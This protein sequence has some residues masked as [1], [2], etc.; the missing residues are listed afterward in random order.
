MHVYAIGLGSNRRHGR[1]GAPRAVVEAVMAAL[2]PVAR[3][4]ILISAPLGPSLRRYANAAVLIKSPL[5]P[6][7]LLAQLKEM[8]RAF[9]R[10]RGRRWG[11]RVLDLDL[12]LW[13]GGAWHER[14][15]TIP[16]ARLVERR[17]ALD[18][19]QQIAPSW[20]ISG[21]RTVRQQAARL[22]RPRP[23]HRSVAGRVRSSVG[24]A[25]DF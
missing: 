25:S 9:G 12:L 11:E 1:Y 15:L 8:E 2:S 4:Q 7:A 18:P 6:P 16:H 21:I 19:L 22:T 14:T 5:L 20:R 17:F 3:S 10:R 23:A 24:R 13:S